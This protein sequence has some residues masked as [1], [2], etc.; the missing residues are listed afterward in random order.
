MN[1]KTVSSIE[2]LYI[3]VGKIENDKRRGDEQEEG[4]G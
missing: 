1:C 4:G 2:N 3:Y